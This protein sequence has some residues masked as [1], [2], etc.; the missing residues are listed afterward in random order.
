MKKKRNVKNALVLSSPITHLFYLFFCNNEHNDFVDTPSNRAA[1]PNRQQD[2]DCWRKLH[3]TLSVFY[4]GLFAKYPWTFS[5]HR[6][7]HLVSN[8][9]SQQWSVIL[10]WVVSYRCISCCCSRPVLDGY[11]HWCLYLTVWITN[12][13]LYDKRTCNSQ[14]SMNISFPSL[15]P[16][17]FTKWDGHGSSFSMLMLRVLH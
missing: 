8:F 1:F 17:S 5:F 3:I 10:F 4:Y 2:H 6:Q 16:Q 15:Q 13:C 11:H 12:V 7:P 9:S 14:I